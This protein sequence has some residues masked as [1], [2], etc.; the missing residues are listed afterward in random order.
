MTIDRWLEWARADAAGRRIEGLE[1]LLDNLAGAIR[2]VRDADWNTP[3]DANPQVSEPD[4]GSA[5]GRTSQAGVRLKPD[6]TSHLSPEP[7]NPAEDVVCQPLTS[8]AKLLKEGDVS[9]RELVEACLARI[10]RLNPSSNAMITTLADPARQEAA[11]ADADRAAGGLHGPLHGI[12]LTLKDLID[13]KGTPTTAASAVRR[14]LVASRDATVTARLLEAGAIIIGKTNLHEFAFGTTNEDSAFGAVRHPVNPAL[15]PGGSSGGSAAAIRAGMCVASIGTD[16]GG[17]IRIPAAACGLVGLKP[18]FGEIPVDGVV[19][20]ASSL[21]HVGPLART[22]EDARVLWNVLAG[23]ARESEVNTEPPSIEGLRLAVLEPYFCDR[24]EEG[25]RRVFF[26]AV[27]RLRL[28]GARVE[29]T[30]LP[31]A[32]LTAPVY[33]V[34]VM[35]EAMAYHAPTLDSRPQDYTAPVR[36]RLEMG[37]YVFGE[38]YVRAQAGRAVLAREVDDC[39]ERADAVVLPTL[40]MAAPVLGANTVMLDGHREPVRGATLRLTQLF[41]VTGHPAVTLPV[42]EAQPGLPAGLQVVGRRNDTARLLA[43]ARVLEHALSA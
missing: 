30:A 4:F 11:R 3:A 18:T 38:D 19:P 27:E 6:A 12:P 40:P 10:E 31:H 39:L 13:L 23:R 16:T 37:R 20:L 15:S 5:F 17:S 35:A 14:G 26:A 28:A 34:I 33:L 25:V 2:A 41:D 21:D 32:A 7:S 24:L 43:I 22:V 8:L 42:A 1:P 36:T 9:A 29:R